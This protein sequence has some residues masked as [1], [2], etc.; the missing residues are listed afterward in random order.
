[1]VRHRGRGAVVRAACFAVCL[2]AAMAQAAQDTQQRLD[3]PFFVGSLG[4][5]LQH[6]R[7]LLIATAHDHGQRLANGCHQLIGPGICHLY[8]G[9]GLAIPHASTHIRS[10]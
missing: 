4:R 3:F 6:S 5:I 2:R 9:L 10:G 8:L 7:D 1:M